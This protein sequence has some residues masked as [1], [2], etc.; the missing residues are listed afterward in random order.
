MVNKTTV[1]STGRP[2]TRKEKNMGQLIEIKT[3]CQKLRVGRTTLD[4]LRK[5]ADFPEPVL[6]VGKLK[7][8]SEEQIEEWLRRQKETPD[9]A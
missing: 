1:A 6:H 7:R 3:I 2:A 9:A 8:W 4:S 5:R